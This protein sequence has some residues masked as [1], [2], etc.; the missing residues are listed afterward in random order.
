MF[1]PDFCNNS[2]SSVS[3]APSFVQTICNLS[4]SLARTTPTSFRRRPT[5]CLYSTR[6][7]ASVSA[8][9]VVSWAGSG[10]DVAG[11][12]A[13]SGVAVDF[14]GVNMRRLTARFEI[15]LIGVAP[16]TK[17]DAY[18]IEEDIVQSVQWCIYAKLFAPKTNLVGYVLAKD[19]S[20]A[21]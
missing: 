17:S 11:A 19:L 8:V 2:G 16:S 5:T 20:L 14:V 21:I 12:G 15:V 18:S 7:P 1:T 6:V 9:I 10:A 4:A 3:F 13:G